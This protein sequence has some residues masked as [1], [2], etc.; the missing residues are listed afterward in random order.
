MSCNREF[1][2]VLVIS[3]LHATSMK[4]EESKS[5][6][7]FKNGECKFAQDF[8]KF[9]GQFK[10]KVD[11]LICAGDV[12]NKGDEESFKLGWS[13]LHQIKSVLGL[14]SLF[15]VP[16][17]HDHHSRTPENLPTSFLENATPSFPLDDIRLNQS[18]WEKQWVSLTH[19]SFNSVLL[20]TSAFHGFGEVDNDYGRIRP[21][22]SQEISDLVS[23]NAQEKDFNVLICHHA[24]YK[25]E[26]AYPESDD[27]EEIQ[28]A[29]NLLHLLDIN[30]HN[31]WL[32]IH[33]HKHF[34][35]VR[36]A[37]SKKNVPIT[38]FSASSLSSKTAYPGSPSVNQFHVLTINL[39]KTR[40]SGRVVGLS[41]NYM[42]DISSP[43]KWRL[44]NQAGFPAISGFGGNIE[45]RKLAG[46]I[47]Q[48]LDDDDSGL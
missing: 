45:L 29:Q 3:D 24:P 15:C 33:G 2:K 46:D 35:D 44:I 37:I 23:G 21:A 17:N 27:N 1:L 25:M 32:V 31:P 42:Y 9:I 30:D 41:H 7:F 16:G 18:F 13:F 11:V 28:G 40:E 26:H 39:E 20:N 22:T 10:S 12:G 19:D 14:E 47:N 38:L 4:G 48:M 6:L 8:L 5:N 34:G 43:E 36:Y